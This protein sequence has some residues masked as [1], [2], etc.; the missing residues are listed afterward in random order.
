M[1][2]NKQTTSEWQI[3]LEHTARDL[4]HTFGAFATGVSVVATRTRNGE[5]RAFTA[6]SFASVSIDPPLVLVCIDKR[7]TSLSEFEQAETFSINILNS[8]QQPLS[9]AFASR[10]PQLKAAASQSMA[11]QVTP[12]LPE[13]LAVFL[14]AQHQRVDAGDHI[15]LIGRVE[16]Y[17][18]CDAEPLVFFR[19]SYVSIDAAIARP[20]GYN[21]RIVVGG[22]LGVSDKVLL[23]RQSGQEKWEIPW[24]KLKSGE[25][26]GEAL[27]ARFQELGIDIAT[28]SLYSLFQETNDLTTTL[29]L[30]VESRDGMESC[31]AT[32]HF[33]SQFFSSDE[34]P[35]DRIQSE[36]TRGLLKRYLDE[37]SRGM[38]GVYFDTIQNGGSIIA[39]DRELLSWNEWMESVLPNHRPIAP[40]P[41]FSP[42]RTEN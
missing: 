20:S 9:N 25:R 23:C 10:D 41:R 12:Y 42:K 31:C 17:R 7:L 1:G 40:Q 29:I 30:S 35:W 15:I 6:N 32:D 34:I 14:C 19:G 24:V 28:S 11:G 37:K 4:R 26:H 18:S 5:I 38:L 13:S 16:H 36:M 39:R 21:S 22:V 3:P 33:E 8:D 2:P 27:R